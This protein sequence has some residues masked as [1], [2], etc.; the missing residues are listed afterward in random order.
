MNTAQRERHLKRVFQDDKTELE[1]ITH[2]VA[3]EENPLL[4]IPSIPVYVLDRAWE[5]SELL[6]S[7]GIC[8]SPGCSSQN[9]WL[10]KS[11]NPRHKQPYFV[12]CKPTGQIVCESSCASYTSA[13]ICV[14]TVAV[15]RHTKSV[16]S[17][18]TYLGKQKKTPNISQLSSVD[19]PK[20]RGKKPQS[21]RKAS[22][23]SSTKKIKEFLDGADI[24]F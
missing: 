3:C 7:S 1:G 10:V 9:E 20:G 4:V 15:A 24:I 6:K 18:L 23:K 2:S 21:K 16:D 22:Q 14:H 11:G 5:G 13:G 19:M 12:E 8:L 17:L